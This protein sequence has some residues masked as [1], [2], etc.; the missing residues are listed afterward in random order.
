VLP[1]GARSVH[2][3]GGV[4]MNVAAFLVFAAVVLGGFSRW[5]CQR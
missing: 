5:G 3:Q 4:G 2:P 1:V